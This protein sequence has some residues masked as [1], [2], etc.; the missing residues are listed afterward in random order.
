[1]KG[2]IELHVFVNR[3]PS[4]ARQKTGCVKRALEDI[5]GGP[6]NNILGPIE[7]ENENRENTEDVTYLVDSHC[8]PER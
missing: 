4:V 2:P 7:E 5:C 8:I 1:M 6:E 3:L